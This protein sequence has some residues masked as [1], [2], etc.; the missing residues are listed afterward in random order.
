[1]ITVSFAAIVMVVIVRD[2]RISGIAGFL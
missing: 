1:M 2:C